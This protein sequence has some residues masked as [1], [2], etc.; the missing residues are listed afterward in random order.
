MKFNKILALTAGV[1]ALF[2]S[3]SDFE[4]INKKLFNV[5]DNA[6]ISFDKICAHL[7]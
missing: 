3:C 1:V 4:E 5:G 7:L 6:Y 2:A